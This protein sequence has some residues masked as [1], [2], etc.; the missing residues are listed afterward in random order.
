MNE[1]PSEHRVRIASLEEAQAHVD[2]LNLRVWQLEQKVNRLDKEAET[3]WRTPFWKR[4]VFAL[5]GWSWREIQT[6]PQW[7]PWHR[8][9]RS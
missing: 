8:W 7:R 6:K 5:D 2:S 1:R 9:V 4:I 3:F